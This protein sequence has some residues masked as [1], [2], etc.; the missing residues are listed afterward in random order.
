[1]QIYHN[2]VRPHM[3]LG[4]RTPSELVGIKVNGEDKWLTIIQNAKLNLE[5]TE[6]L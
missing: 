3:S 2:F 4:E 5:R 1:M 6:E